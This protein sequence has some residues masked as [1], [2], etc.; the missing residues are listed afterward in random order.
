MSQL[1]KVKVLV[2][3]E[4]HGF[5]MLIKFKYILIDTLGFPGGASGKESTC[6]SRRHKRC[7]F[8]PQVRKIPWKRKW[9]PTPV[10]FPRKSMDRGA[11]WAILRGVTGV[12]HDLAIRLPLP[13]ELLNLSSNIFFLPMYLI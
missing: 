10:F 8:N 2:N 9:Q 3:K 11:W 12:P 13:T 1:L 6:Q 5:Q 4:G 7:G